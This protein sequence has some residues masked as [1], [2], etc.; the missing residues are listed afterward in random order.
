[1]NKEALAS[2]DGFSGT[3]NYYQH[4]SRLV[5][6]D[7]V[8]HLVENAGAYWLLDIISSYQNM[9]SRDSMLQDMQF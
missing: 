3:E 6:T 8:K 2:L 7:G 9:A 5:Y 1:M 4:S